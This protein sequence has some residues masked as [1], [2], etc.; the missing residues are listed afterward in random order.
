MYN[1]TEEDS[2]VQWTEHCAKIMQI[3]MHRPGLVCL[4]AKHW[5]RMDLLYGGVFSKYKYSA[6]VWE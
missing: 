3:I 6:C 5:W 4:F 1:R 2:L